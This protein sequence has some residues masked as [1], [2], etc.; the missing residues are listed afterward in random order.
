MG[1]QDYK[2]LVWTLDESPTRCQ[3]LCDAE[4]R[5]QAWTFYTE[6]NRNRTQCWLKHTVPC[7]SDHNEC[8]SGVKVEQNLNPDC[9]MW[10]G[11]HDGYHRGCWLNYHGKVHWNE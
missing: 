6:K 7:T 10:K 11:A 2:H 9:Q 1:G 4:E 3:E 5:C 8:V